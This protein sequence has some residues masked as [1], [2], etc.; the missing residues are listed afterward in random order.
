MKTWQDNDILAGRYRLMRELGRDRGAVLWEA[1]DDRE[2]GLVH[3]RILQHNL[4]GEPLVVMRFTREA[5]L[6]GR[7]DHPAL[8]A[9]RELIDDEEALTLVYD[10]P[11]TM[12]LAERLRR[13]VVDATA[14]AILLEPVLEGLEFAHRRGV[15]HRNLSP[16]HIW[17]DGAGGARVS[18]F[19]A[20]A[21]PGRRSQRRPENAHT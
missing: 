16:D 21:N 9:A 3:L 7:L 12:T 11:G 13:G 20:T 5:A 17:L 2:M 10:V 14:A 15:I 19:G 6:A 4:R 1:H 8:S 18:G